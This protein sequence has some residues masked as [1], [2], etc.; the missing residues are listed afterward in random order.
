MSAPRILIVEDDVEIADFLA[1]GLTGEGYIV[2]VLPDGHGLVE[3]VR[4]A[5]FAVVILDRMLPDA[6]GAELCRK[7]RAAGE[8]VMILMLTAKDALDDKLEGLRAGADDYMTK[9][10]AFAELLAR[11]EVLRRHSAVDQPVQNEI[12]V[13]DIRLD[14]SLKTAQRAGRELGLTATEFALLRHFSENVGRVVSRM[15]LLRA[16]WGYDFDP[17]TNIVEVYIAY[18]RKKLDHNGT[19]GTIQT[20]RGFGYLFASDQTS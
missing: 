15:D 5:E 1:T 10:F 6:E 13:G 11:L 19:S 12:V 7:L 9:P 2:T 3:K 20:V 4:G 18:L 14:L 16:V 8:N 17:H